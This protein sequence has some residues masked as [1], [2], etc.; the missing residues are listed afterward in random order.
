MLELTCHWDL[1]VG[2]DEFAVL[3]AAP[4][5]VSLSLELPLR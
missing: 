1:Q 3:G 2:L 5:P 4:T